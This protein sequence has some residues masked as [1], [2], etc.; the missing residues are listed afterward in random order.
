MFNTISYL[1]KPYQIVK[2]KNRTKKIFIF[3]KMYILIFLFFLICSLAINIIYELFFYV[4]EFNA[5]AKTLNNNELYLALISLLFIS[6]FIEEFTFRLWL[7]KFNIKSFRI[8]CSLLSSLISVKLFNSL[9]DLEVMGVTIYNTYLLLSIFF[10]FYFTIYQ[11][12]FNKK[13]MN[14][15]ENFWNKY[16]NVIF[17]IIA[18]VFTLLH[19][20]SFNLM[21]PNNSFLYYFYLIPI[22]TFSLALGFIRLNY[23]LKY[24]ILFHVLFNL[25]G[26]I[27]RIIII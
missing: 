23:G 13:K 26:V 18:L 21:F 5:D 25:P 8:S 16:F 14:S 12:L 4:S 2:N 10:I 9:F 17:Y 11:Y 6:P 20:N 1:L 15:I 27:T 22:Y 19:F 24:C 7:G 3:F